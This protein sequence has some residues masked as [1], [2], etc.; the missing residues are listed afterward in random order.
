[1]CPIE[2]DLSVAPYFDDYTPDKDEQMVIFQPSVSVQ[3]RELNELQSLL[4]AQIERFGD[5]ILKSGTILSGC[6]F[7]FN[8]GYCYVKL[9]DNEVDGTIAIP[10]KYVGYFAK[11]TSNL[12]SVIINSQ[13]GFESTDPN[14]KTAY[15]HYRN[16]GS[17]SNTFAYTPGDLLT[18]YDPNNIIFDVTINNGG[19]NFSNSDVV[20]FTPTLA[21]NVSSGTFTN[22]EYIVNPVTGANVQIVNIDDLTLAT[23][24]Q[25]ILSVA[26][27][28]VDLT[29][30]VSNSS[31][32]TMA[33][34]D[35]IINA[36]NTVVATI[37]TVYGQGANASIVTDGTGR[38]ININMVTPGRNYDI[39]PTVRV[40]SAN[41]VSGIAAV[42]LTA[43]NYLATIKVANTVDA[44]GNGYLFSVS[45]GMIYQKGRFLRVANQS[46]IVS[47]YTET[48]N[49]ISVGFVTEEII[50]DSNQDPTLLD[51][52]TGTENEFAPGANRLVMTP[53]LATLQSDLI[54]ANSHFLPVVSFSEG[55]PFRLQQSTAYSQIG[56]A[57]AKGISEIQ[58]DFSIDK[59]L[60]TTRSPSNA[61]FEGNVFSIVVDP[62]TSYI[63]GYRV[64]TVRNFVLDVTKGMDI[65]TGNVISIPVSYRN[66]IRIKEVGGV[67]QFSTGDTVKFY[68]TPKTFLSNATLASTS[69]T[70]P[71]GNLIGSARVRSMVYE[72][73][74]PGSANA[75]YRLYLFN[76]VM[77]TGKNFTS[78]RSVY[79]NGTYKG[80]ADIIL[81]PDAT[82]NANDAVIHYP[83]QDTLLFSAGVE[84]L[85]NASNTSYTYRTID[86]TLTISNTG[87]ITKSL[88]SV[89]NEFFPYVGALTTAE[90]EDLYVVPLANLQASSNI[91]GS[92]SI[93]GTSNSLIGTTTTFISDLFAGDFVLLAANST[94]FDV[95]QIMAV[96]NSTLA[97]MDKAS[98]ITNSSV[99]IYRYFPA[100]V[101]IP[102]GNRPGF[103]AALNGNG[104]ILTANIGMSLV[105]STST[106]VAMAVNIDRQN[107]SAGTKT[108]SRDNFVLLCLS[109]NAGGTSGP[110]CLGVPD[111]IRLKAV[112]VGNSSVNTTSNNIVGD[113]FIDHNQNQN[114]Y[115]LGWLMQSPTAATTLSNTQYLLVQFDCL[116]VSNT[117]FYDT[118]SYMSSNVQ[119]VAVTDS[120]PLNSLGSM[121][122]TWEIPEIY[123]AS[124]DYY[125][126]INNF[127]FRPISV[128]TA[129]L[130]ANYALATL[131]PANTLSFGNTANPAN[132]K[133]FPLP[134]S[135]MFTQITEY[136]G[137][138]DGVYVGKDGNIFAIKGIPSGTA[139]KRLRPNQ[140]NGSMKLNEIAVPSYPNLPQNPSNVVIQIINT[141]MANERYTQ[142]RINNHSINTLLSSGQIETDQPRN[143]TMAEIGTLDR[144]IQS[145]EYYQSLSLLETDVN[146]RV[147]PSSVDP[148]LDRFKFGF[149]ADDYSTPVSQDTT[150]PQYNAALV[151]D[152]LVPNSCSWTVASSSNGI[153]STN[154]TDW[155]IISQPYATANVVVVANTVANT[156]CECPTTNTSTNVTDWDIFRSVARSQDECGFRDSNDFDDFDE[157][158][159]ISYGH[160]PCALFFATDSGHC[161]FKVFR[162][163]QLILT[164]DS[165]IAI[166]KTGTIDKVA[167]GDP[168]F[169]GL[170]FGSENCN[171]F[172]EFAQGHG[173]LVLPDFPNDPEC[174]VTISVSKGLSCRN[175]K[176][177]KVSLPAA[178]ASCPCPNTTPTPIKTIFTGVWQEKM[179]MLRT[180]FNDVRTFVGT[181]T[182][183]SSIKVTGNASTGAFQGNVY[184]VA[185]NGATKY[186]GA[187]SD[188]NLL[189]THFDITI[190]GLRPNCT[191]D[192]LVQGINKN[193]RTKTNNVWGAPLITDASGKLAFMYD[194]SANQDQD[195]SVFGIPAAGQTVTFN[196]D[197]TGSSVAPIS[198][199]TDNSTANVTI[200]TEMTGVPPGFPSPLISSIH[201]IVQ[202]VDSSAEGYIDLGT[203]L[204]LIY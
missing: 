158:F 156:G 140:P 131:N 115:D 184:L 192:L 35:S 125:D 80:I 143:Y 157:Q 33:L 109:N 176:W 88:A 110:W 24:G 136:E 124:G 182:T 163:G 178:S 162:N 92:G 166:N 94:V 62:G 6:N 96:A 42:S 203:A 47:K 121:I 145:L 180:L 194:Y 151:N 170:N 66:Y 41:N 76:V 200:T 108:A 68:D 164:S 202:A 60:V 197:N 90:M 196:L 113:Y 21:V 57:I 116:T 165:A 22:G 141:R 167:I 171:K 98:A 107:V 133:K 120:V 135:I 103:S 10:A 126:L 31:F 82:T 179:I 87:L 27:R 123:T 55:N 44:V 183:G 174:K 72:S 53:E 32:W 154:Y 89:P 36:G 43:V 150:N 81:E 97:V 83:S 177:I 84:S 85:Q 2:T 39:V 74:I 61:M 65:D 99:S 160:G 189:E 138:I 204:R 142:Q 152:C 139:T 172:S 37:E 195:L 185:A 64:K 181:N 149:F 1:M 18:I 112:Y 127:D 78:I 86:Q 63:D 23:E 129:I 71:Q 132:D 13:D 191:H 146:N 175:W 159:N 114:Y 38:I 40:K 9:V 50:V 168:Q 102:F 198:V 173:K 16:A 122:N 15:I 148:T 34:G 49:N 67:F 54:G 119:Q 79:Y 58:G 25:V 147:I 186:V 144:R 155:C 12:Q 153:Y 169:F 46:V 17:D 8:P 201:L 75:A 105:G 29:N 193:A 93:N 190:T 20:V 106:N 59:F 69:N 45:G 161:K 48:P 134:D 77:N 4:Y 56:D 95:R 5:N 73:G 188:S 118:V 30:G 117:G 128:N 7:I 3:T 51:N 70:T 91:S 199:I 28:S 11:N 100:Y 101:P 137:R 19:V 26:A 111:I 14:L 104:N 130:T 187:Y 52:A